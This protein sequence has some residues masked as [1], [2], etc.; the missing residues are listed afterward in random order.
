MNAAKEVSLFV[1]GFGP[2]LIVFG[3]LAVFTLLFVL[4]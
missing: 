4:L 3:A 1:G 2:P